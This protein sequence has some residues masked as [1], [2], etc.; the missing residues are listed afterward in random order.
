MSPAV[1]K[2]SS[3]AMELMPVYSVNHLEN[4]LKEAKESG[5]EILGTAGPRIPHDLDGNAD[6]WHDDRK[7]RKEIPQVDCREFTK[8]GPTLLAL[9]R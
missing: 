7:K 6:S 8:Q 2:A 5:W 4:F 1:S 9:G 3:G